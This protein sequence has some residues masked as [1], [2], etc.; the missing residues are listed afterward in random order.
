MNK[1][2]DNIIYTQMHKG[3]KAPEKTTA[4]IYAHTRIK[5]VTESYRFTL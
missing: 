2:N 3:K 1:T 5:M 4:S